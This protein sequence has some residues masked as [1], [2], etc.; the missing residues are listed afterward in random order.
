MIRKRNE[1]LNSS[2]QGDG[3]DRVPPMRFG[4]NIGTR[5][6]MTSLQ[7]LDLSVETT[8]NLNHDLP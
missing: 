8:E 7:S 2:S 3:T 6:A 1:L 4:R 5:D